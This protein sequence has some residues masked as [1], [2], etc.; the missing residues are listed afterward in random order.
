MLA[1][2]PRVGMDGLWPSVVILNSLQILAIGAQVVLG[3]HTKLPDSRPRTE[4][5][6]WILVFTPLSPSWLVTAYF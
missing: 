1:T 2:D 4:D 3:L 6:S 5:S